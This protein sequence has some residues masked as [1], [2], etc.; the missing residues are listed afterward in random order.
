M[1][2]PLIYT[3]YWVYRKTSGILEE[4]ISNPPGGSLDNKIGQI[5]KCIIHH[6]L[7]FDVN[8]AYDIKIQH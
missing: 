3:L 4:L 8:D 5:V 2:P 1:I 7:T 6:N